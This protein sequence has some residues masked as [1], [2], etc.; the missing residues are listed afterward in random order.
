MRSFIVIATLLLV[1][2]A[3]NPDVERSVSKAVRFFYDGAIEEHP[4]SQLALGI[5]YQ[6]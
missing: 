4:E 1:G 5:L 2:C 6:K 3:T